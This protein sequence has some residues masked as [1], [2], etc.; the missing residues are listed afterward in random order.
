MSSIKFTE[1]AVKDLKPEDRR[2]LVRESGHKGFGIRVNPSGTKTWVYSY[3]IKGRQR[4][5]T[6]GHYPDMSLSDARAVHARARGEF[7]KGKDPGALRKRSRDFE[8]SNP[9][10]RQLAEKYLEEYAKP[11][12]KSWRED[13]RM[14]HKD[15]LPFWSN[16]RAKDITRLDIRTVLRKIYDRRAPVQSNRMLACLRR[17]FAFGLEEGFLEKS[18][19]SHVKPVGKEKRKDRILTEDEIRAF[20][21]GLD[22]ARISDALNKALR[23][24]LVTGQRPGEV[25]GATWDEFEGEWWTIKGDRNRNRLPHRV[26]L[27]PLARDIL[28]PPGEGFVFPSPRGAKPIEVNALGHALRRN[29][30]KW[31]MKGFTSGDLR[32]T[33]VSN[34]AE[35]GISWLTV[36]KILN[37]SDRQVM[38]AYDPHDHDKEKRQTLEKWS[39][40]LKEIIEGKVEG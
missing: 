11:K 3:T 17:M 40:R 28:G 32:R 15:L 12:K 38:I 36:Q 27:S 24:I 9:T 20:W 29:F 6:L 31:K 39:R 14:L 34:M 13:Q 2:Y 33:A 18:P 21:K 8:S 22:D 10:V 25:L 23:L 16:R 5:M 37:Y 30:K 19:C 4:W 7:L 35:I 26:Y 1:K